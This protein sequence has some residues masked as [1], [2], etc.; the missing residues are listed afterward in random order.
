MQ[1]AGDLAR[2]LVEGGAG[3]GARFN[4]VVGR[5]AIAAGG[6]AADGA[7]AGPVEHE[8]AGVGFAG[9]AD[10]ETVLVAFDTG[11]VAGVVV[12]EDAHRFD[13]RQSDVNS[14]VSVLDLAALENGFETG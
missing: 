2:P 3:F 11:K 12:L 8:V 5:L 14:R 10:D 1:F 9:C 7:A 4:E 6:F 13:L